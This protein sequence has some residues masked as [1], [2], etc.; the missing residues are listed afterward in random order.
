VH[1]SNDPR[2]IYHVTHVF[3]CGFAFCT[4][5]LLLAVTYI[6]CCCVLGLYVAKK[7]VAP[8]FLL[9]V[10]LLVQLCAVVVWL[11]L[12]VR[13]SCSHVL[14]ACYSQRLRL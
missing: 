1:R 12:G 13:L 5:G 9:S 14:L 6:F 2:C 7:G 8:D 11:G 10:Q 4:S 3:W